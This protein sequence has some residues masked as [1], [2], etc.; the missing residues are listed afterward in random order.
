MAGLEAILEIVQILTLALI[1]VGTIVLGALVAPMIFKQL[2][3]I[4]AGVT[5][6]EIFEKFSQWTEVA[7]L[8]LFTSKL[9]E[10]VFIRKFNFVKDF[11]FVNQT[12]IASNFD[13]EYL[14]SL[15]LVVAIFAI[16]LYISLELMPKMVN[17]F[18]DNEKEFKELH[19][20]SEKLMK[21]NAV[22]AIIALIL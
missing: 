12:K 21:L 9:I 10:L 4:E 22:L 6:T 11:F 5:M 20:K 17:A 18:E 16:S 3:R 14:F 19:G 7:A 13:A 1:A 2:S 8:A 15:I